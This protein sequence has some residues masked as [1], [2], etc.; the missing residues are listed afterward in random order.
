MSDK[1]EAV[2]KAAL[3]VPPND[4][5]SLEHGISASTPHSRTQ[6]RSL[7]RP[8]RI[9]VRVHTFDAFKIRNFRLLWLA[10]IGS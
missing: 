8:A 1:Q 9:H 2:N 3:D 5:G 6:L 7:L 10:S 4:D